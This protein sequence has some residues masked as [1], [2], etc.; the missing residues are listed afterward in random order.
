MEEGTHFPFPHILL[1]VRRSYKRLTPKAA[2]FFL[3][4]NVAT[5]RR[6]PRQR[7]S[8]RCVAEESP[9]QVTA[10]FLGGERG[11][12]LPSPSPVAIRALEIHAWQ[13]PLR[14]TAERMRPPRDPSVPENLERAHRPDQRF[15]PCATVRREVGARRRFS[16]RRTSQRLAVVPDGG[17]P[18]VAASARHLFFPVARA[19][20]SVRG[21]CG[22][23]GGIVACNARQLRKGTVR[24]SRR[25]AVSPCRARFFFKSGAALEA[26]GRPES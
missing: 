15:T 7:R 12:A 25:G 5:R 9:I 14:G 16:S 10:V 6:H 26:P 20:P 23:A 2:T 21:R 8:A 24:S 22:V 11:D 19:Y 17:E 18:R 13:P 1:R 4:E 3:A